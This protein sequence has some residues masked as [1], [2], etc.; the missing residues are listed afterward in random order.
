MTEKE[1]LVRSWLVSRRISLAN[2][3][4]FGHRLVVA[5]CYI[6]IVVIEID[7]GFG[8]LA[9]GLAI[10]GKLL[11]KNNRLVR[12]ACRCLRRVPRQVR[13]QPL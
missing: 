1:S 6:Q 10:V 13:R 5:R 4:F 11:N 7:P 9:S 8:S 3:I 12:L 2:P